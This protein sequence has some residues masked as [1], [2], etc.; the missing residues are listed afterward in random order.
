LGTNNCPKP[1][2]LPKN[3]GRSLESRNKMPIKFLVKGKE[4]PFKSDQATNVVEKQ[5][6]ED[7]LKNNVDFF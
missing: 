3:V 6:N 7:A 1:K 4:E 2:K 5:L